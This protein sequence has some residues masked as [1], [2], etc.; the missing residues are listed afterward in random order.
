MRVLKMYPLAKTYLISPS[1][2][3]ESVDDDEEEVSMV[4]PSK[5]KPQTP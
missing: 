5:L 2:S 3:D 4:V 1:K